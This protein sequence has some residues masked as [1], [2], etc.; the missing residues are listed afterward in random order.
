RDR[1]VTG[2]QTCALPISEPGVTTFTPR[3]AKESEKTN[4]NIV[5]YGDTTLDWVTFVLGKSPKFG[6][7]EAWSRNCGNSGTGTHSSALAPG[8]RMRTKRLKMYA[9]LV[10]RAFP[11]VMAKTNS[12]PPRASMT[13]PATRMT[14][15]HFTGG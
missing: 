15:P 5:P 11:P 1:N 12:N 13:T 2:V 4:R 9:S 3:T 8:V 6:S 7:T 14:S 10:T